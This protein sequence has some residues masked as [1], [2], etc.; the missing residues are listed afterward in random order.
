MTS[1][2]VGRWA[3]A[4]IAALVLAG[5]G[6]PPGQFIIVQDQV[7]DPGCVIPTTLGAVYR[8]TGDLDVRVVSSTAVA[9]YVLFPLLQN[10]LS[11]PQG[12]ASDPNRIALSGYDV[13]V[14]LAPDATLTGPITDLFNGLESGQPNGVPSPLVEFSVPTSGSVA[15]GGGNTSSAVDVVQA[16]LARQMHTMWTLSPSMP[17]YIYLTAIV[18]ARG[19]TLQ[20]S[21]ESDAFNFPIRVCD[22]CLIAN[23]D[24]LPVCPVTQA[25]TNVGNTCNVAQD[26]FVDCCT[27]GD[28]LVCPS[29]VASQ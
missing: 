1:R 18:R 3:L 21:V 28:E 15:S 12:Q 17:A 16:E 19:K 29:A 4:G 14:T 24:S 11:P 25:P 22:G 13:H 2:T 20:G 8:A 23:V 9:G 26:G 10:N 7:P 5:C 6:L 27:F